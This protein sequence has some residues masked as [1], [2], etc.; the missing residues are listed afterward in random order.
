MREGPERETVGERSVRASAGCTWASRSRIVR[1]TWSTHSPR[2]CANAW[3]CAR[4]SPC[5]RGAA[6][7]YASCRHMIFSAFPRSAV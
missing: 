5:W 2:T 6:T 7:G 4:T 1:S 3:L